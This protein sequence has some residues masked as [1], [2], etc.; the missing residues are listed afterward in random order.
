MRRLLVA[1]SLGLATTAEGGL[2][3]LQNVD[4]DPEHLYRLINIK[5][6]KPGGP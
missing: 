1:V 5:L 2:T 3:G 6:A 4:I